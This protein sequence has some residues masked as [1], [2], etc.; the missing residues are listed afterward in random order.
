MKTLILSLLAA[1]GLLMALP[2]APKAE[3]ASSMFSHDVYS[4]EDG[5]PKWIGRLVA[6]RLSQVITQ[7]PKMAPEYLPLSLVRT[8]GLQK[9]LEEVMNTPNVDT[10]NW[11]SW[12]GRLR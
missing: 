11:P 4:Y 2:L 6:G 3:A 7:K 1:S 5:W 8:G 9:L 12:I 10:T